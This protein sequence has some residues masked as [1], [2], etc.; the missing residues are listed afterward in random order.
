MAGRELGRTGLRGRLQVPTEDLIR[1]MPAEGESMT[2]Q[3]L[4]IDAPGG[5]QVPVVEVSLTD[6]ETVRLYDSSGPG[7]DWDRGLSP[8]RE[9]WITARGDVEE[10]GARAGSA[11][12]D[13]R[14]ASRRGVRPELPEAGKRPVRRARRGRRVTQ[15]AY[16]RE[17]EI[18]SEMNF[19]A[20][21]EG[22]DPEFVRAEV[23]AGRAII[24]ANI[25]HPESEPMAIG[26]NFL[27]KV[28]ATSATRPCGRPST[29]RW[30]SWRGPPGGEPTR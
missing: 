21:R 7:S 10:I 15:L 3:R 28:N 12:D 9:G 5:I 17:G 23:A 27:V 11:R 13:G 24:P 22:L 6:G 16:A 14:A 30:R 4:L 29:T 26:R 25:N 2:R 18:T 8:L 1:V 19:V 20:A